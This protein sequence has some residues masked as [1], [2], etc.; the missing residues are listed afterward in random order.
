MQNVRHGET[1]LLTRRRCS[2]RDDGR[3]PDE[4]TAKHEDMLRARREATVRLPLRLGCCRHQRRW[5]RRH[6]RVKRDAREVTS[7]TSERVVSKPTT[8]RPRRGYTCGPRRTRARGRAGGTRTGR[9]GARLGRTNHASRE[10]RVA[11][12]RARAALLRWD[13][14]TGGHAGGPQAAG[15]CRAQVR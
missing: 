13:L 6:A 15:P 2:S 4:L 11:P 14:A 3:R 8:R 10:Q 12:T 1:M 5:Q 7:G 9:A